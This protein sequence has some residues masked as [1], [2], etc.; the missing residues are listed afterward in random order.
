[1]TINIGVVTSDA[2]ILG[3]DSV[4]SVTTPMINP[5]SQ[6]FVRDAEGQFIKDKDGNFLVPVT[7]S[8]IEH[9]VT[10]VMT[11]V[12]KM[13][14]IYDDKK[15]VVAATTAGMGKI[16][17]RPIAGVAYDF[18]GSL[19][20]KG[21]KFSKFGD[22]VNAFYEYIRAEYEKDQKATEVPEEHW[23]TLNFLVGGHGKGDKF[24]SLWRVKVKDKKVDCE[25]ESGKTGMCW[26]GQADTVEKVIRGYDGELRYTIET[27]VTELLNSHHETMSK[28][29]V[30]ILDDTLKAL[31]ATMPADINT[32][33]PKMPEVKIEWEK[34]KVGVSYSN[35]PLQEAINFVSFL[36]FT[37]AGKLKFAP[38]PA[39]VGGRIHIGYATRADGFKM[40]NEPD[41]THKHTGFAYD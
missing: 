33:L 13:F 23:S 8:G 18:A 5:F 21:K 22:V 35:L 16:N 28:T 9:I 11:G 29:I 27:Y 2:L 30:R 12:T 14:K 24:P 3:C 34:F 32:E 41:L 20:T 26:A 25:F 38:G 17:D 31:K 7:R 1:M 4:A 6:P 10:D 39:T 36:A 15:T 19:K 40:L 37:Q